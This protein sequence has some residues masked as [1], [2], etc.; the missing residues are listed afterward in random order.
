MKTGTKLINYLLAA[1]VL[2][3]LPAAVFALQNPF[4]T[5]P[6]TAD[7]KPE[8]QVSGGG[9]FYNSDF[10]IMIR[11]KQ[12]I[13][14]SRISEYI[15]DYKTN[16]N[17]SIL[18]GFL[19]FSFLYGLLHVIGP[20]HRKVFLFT[21]FISKP[22]KWKQGMAAGF[23]TAVL[24]ALSAVII[25]GGLYFIATKTLL[26]RFN[27]LTPVLE[28]SSYAAIIVIG[29]Y[30]LAHSIIDFLMGRPEEN[31]VKRNPDTM[32]FIIFSGLVPCPGAAA[33]MIFSISM[34]AA[35]IGIY[36]IIAMSLGMGMVLAVIPPA[37]ILIKN[38][39]Q[40]LIS[41]WKPETGE[42]LHALI[43]AAGAALLILLGVFFII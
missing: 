28:K 8:E 17:L 35:A 4:L 29:V 31:K 37:A 34:N 10:M 27:N 43:G 9:R 2:F 23:F 41:G 42:R 36:S 30:L 20:G 26:T 1:A 39:I 12:K 40:P 7:V 11:E 24:H 13:I 16:R 5:A 19:G 14:Q 33:I 22:A 6:E 3:N 38:R 15:S 25:I 32:L 21:Y 18:A